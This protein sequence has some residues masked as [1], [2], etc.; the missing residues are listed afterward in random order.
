VVRRVGC[1]PIKVLR[2][3]VSIFFVVFYIASLS[4]FLMALQCN[5][6]SHDKAIRF[7]MSHFDKGA[8]KVQCCPQQEGELRP[9][10]SRTQQRRS[11]PALLSQATTV[12][13]TCVALCRSNVSFDNICYAVG[14]YLGTATH[15][16]WP[17]QTRV[18]DMQAGRV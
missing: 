7:H 3:V 8:T 16:P 14:T 9:F 18:R 5:Y 6:F 15:N 17:P 12:C 2:L 4:V 11:T 13:V 1:R 10:Q